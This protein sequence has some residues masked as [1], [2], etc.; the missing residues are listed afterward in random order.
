MGSPRDAMLL[1]RTPVRPRMRISRTTERRFV[2]G[3]QG[4]W[5]GRRWKGRGGVRQALA[6]CRGIQVDPLDVVGQNADLVLASRVAGYRREQLDV[7][8]YRERVAFEW[9]GGVAIHPRDRLPLFASW[10]RTQG[11]PARWERWERQ[12][13][14]IVERVRR[15]IEARG[16]LGARDYDDGA[17]TKNYRG[18]TLEALA[19]YLLWRRLEVLVHHRDGVEKQYDRTDRLFGEVGAPFDP[20][21]TLDRSALETLG[22]LGLSGR[23]GVSYL[24]TQEDGR[25]RSSLRKS[26]IRERLLERGAL[27]PVEVEGERFPSVVRREDLPLLETVA[28]GELPRSWRPL[29]PE[30]EAVLLAPLDVV[31]ARDRARSLFDF[32][33]LF[34]VYKPAS[35]RRW[36]YYVLPILLGDRL[37]GRFEP[38]LRSGDGALIV[39]RAWWEA[40]V[41]LATVVDPL[42]RGLRRLADRLGTPEIRLGRI[43]PTTFRDRLRDRLGSRATLPS[44][45]PG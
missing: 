21:E 28:A 8:L 31:V 26:E 20:A 13:A 39:E 30:P 36:G 16:P 2:L 5:P 34:E 35:E 10:V 23:Y 37:V 38:R 12:H 45:G 11:L 41:P 17:R 1:S 22:W 25:G 33:Y 18:G 42:A 14:A 44:D 24:R 32:E 43:G 29:S 9:G 27:V 40:G 4:L 7:L 3:L 6:A 19:L 15:D